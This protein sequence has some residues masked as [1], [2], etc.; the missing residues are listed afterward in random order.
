MVD[1][2]PVQPDS[3]A[4][5]A[6]V[7]AGVLPVERRGR[8][9][10]TAPEPSGL[11]VPPWEALD[12]EQQE[13]AGLEFGC[14]P[15]L[16][17]GAPGTGRTT[18][19]VSLAA[20]RLR[21]GLSADNL[22]VLTPSRSS[23]ARVR[24][25]LTATVATTMST[26]PVR[27]WQA[28]AFDLLRRAHVQGRL[29]GV[30][31]PPKLLSGPEQDV[32]I[33]ELMEGH[34]HGIGA[35]V[36]WPPDL[37]E[38][39]STRGF[40]QEMRELFDRL[41][42]HDLSPEDLADLGRRLGR[43]DWVVASSLRA[44]YQAV[45]RLRMPEAFDPAELVTE[46]ARLLENDPEMLATEQ[47]RLELVLVDDLQ[48]A[49]RS[50]HR[51]L[52]VLC[53]GRDVIM[54]ACPDTVVQGF[55]GARPDALR[56]LTDRVGTA[57]APL[58]THLLVTGHRM[59]AEIQEAWGRV[60]ARVPAVTGQSPRSRRPSPAPTPNTASAPGPESSGS[61]ASAAQPGSGDSGLHAVVLASE[62]HEARWIGHGILRRHLLE[63]VPF[64]DMAVVVRNS[65]RLKSVQRQLEGLGIPVTTSAAETP[66]RDE[67]AVKPLL[68]ALKL[69][70]DAHHNDQEPTDES[71]SLLAAV[72]AVDLLGSR[73]GGA[74]AM[75][76]RRLRQRLRYA[77]LRDGGG[78]NSD[79][80]LVE[81]LVVPGALDA[82][83]V[84]ST[85]ARRIARMV[86]AGR[87]AL[88]GPNA[89]AETV[90]WAL[91]EAAG[92]ADAWQ[93][94]ALNGAEAGR[95]ADRDLDAVVGLFEMAER[96][97]NH[98]PGAGA[99][100]FLDF[101]ELQE[102][103]MDTLA[104]RAPTRATVEIMTPATAAG[105]EWPVVFVAGVQEGQWPNTTL[106]G[107]LLGADLLDDAVELGVEAAAR[108]SPVTRV[109]LVRHD[110]LRSFSTAV[111]RAGRE[112]L[113]SAVVDQDH[114]PSDFLGLVDPWEVSR[115]PEA[116]ENSRPVLKAP[117]PLT[118]RAFTGQL[119][120][121][122]G[123]G[124]EAP[125][126]AEAAARLLHRLTRTRTPVPGAHPE[127]WW[128]LLPLS[129]EG[130]VLDPDQPVPVSPS[131][132]ETISRSPLDWFVSTARAEEATDAARSLG[133]L[134]HSIAEE[135]PN[136]SGTELVAQLERR[137]PELGLP[138]GWETD[139]LLERARTMLR[140]FAAYVIDARKDGGRELVAVEGSFSVLVRG[141][142]RD[143]LLRG[144]VDRLEV[145]AQ[146]RYVVVD[147]KT[148][149]VQPSGADVARHPQMGTYQVALAAGA[150]EAMAAAARSQDDDAAPDQEAD[151][152]LDLG[153]ESRVSDPG[154]AVLVQ[155][156][157]TT[158]GY[159]AQRQ[160]PLAPDERWAQELVTAAAE[161]VSRDHFIARHTGQNTGSY[162][163][164]C[165]LPEICP[166]CSQGRQVTE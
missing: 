103:P 76:I 17:L 65:A 21:E 4:Q 108:T 53:A 94:E 161:L 2:S 114:E 16:V 111:S 147:L 148:G 95:R 31:N 61:G 99:A 87:A 129:S 57:A 139:L 123:D 93:R 34:A 75:D 29:P 52:A 112:L 127:Q 144:R 45:R 1:L 15:R 101:L 73:I 117:R 165:R 55:R 85:P 83:G 74:S 158:S 62:V 3:A 122:V 59:P 32:L 104:A 39:V 146:G 92:V 72:E 56:G 132:I 19:L 20:R 116:A 86:Q 69:V 141:R 120:A 152:V 143:A 38:A 66:V 142:A 105:R 10:I 43:Q 89:T 11:H 145:D 125:E 156:G 67:P 42:E 149:A 58:R 54:T 131:R 35:G 49:T 33:R 150:G 134:V 78:R 137:W 30:E 60:A 9:A 154:G 22:L 80:L 26:P 136:G 160:D 77:E 18:A 140:K 130:P 155:L 133:T 97:V 70:V 8:W 82:A 27:A 121:A 163:M 44:E 13:I 48:E 24:D 47:Q 96:F 36:V 164:R 46:A 64:Q 14:G 124:A 162:G 90:L 159:T 41:S 119:R 109:T 115:H 151:L 84:R 153:P 98:L 166:L 71:A 25:T 37:Q 81:A 28:Y 102:L 79:Q 12:P 40:R 106:R 110:E 135:F 100:E 138:T 128:G 6:D 126:H 157:R 88:G 51:L 118:L 91:W 7:L 23:A 63:G 5:D 113:V 50:I 107:Q 68:D